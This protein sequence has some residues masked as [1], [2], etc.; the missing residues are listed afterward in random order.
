MYSE[1]RMHVETIS[2]LT[3][4]LLNSGKCTRLIDAKVKL[5]LYRKCRKKRTQQTPKPQEMTE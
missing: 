3:L 1:E 4:H 2:S 5:R